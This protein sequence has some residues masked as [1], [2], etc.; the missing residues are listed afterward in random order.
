MAF[1]TTSGYHHYQVMP[2]GLAGAPSIFHLIN[3]VLRECLVRYVIA[4]IDDILINSCDLQIHKM[5]LKHEQQRL[6]ENHL[7]V[8]GEFHQER[9]AF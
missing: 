3:H 2:Y 9:V 4:N 7:H 8:K 5:H 6:R 1:S